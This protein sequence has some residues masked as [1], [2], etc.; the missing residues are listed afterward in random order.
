MKKALLV[1]LVTA[2]YFQANAQCTLGAAPNGGDGTP[3]LP[4]APSC[5]NQNQTTNGVGAGSFQTIPG[6]T[7]STNYELYYNTQGAPI[8]CVTARFTTS[9]GTPATAWTN[10]N[11]ANSAPG[12]FTALQSCTG[13]DRLEVRT[14]RSSNWINTSAL[15]YYRLAK[16]TITS[17]GTVAPVC[18]SA[19]S[20]TTTLPYTATTNSPTSYSI[21]WASGLTDVGT[22]SLAFSSGSGTVTISVPAGLAAG[23]YTGVM[24]ITNSNACTATLNITLTIQALPSI[25]TNPTNKSACAAGG[26][27]FTV[28]GA[29]TGVAYAWQVSTD[30]GTTFANITAAGTNPTYAN[31]TTSTLGLSGIV[32]GNSGYQYRAV[33]SGTCTPSVTSTAATLTVVTQPSVTTAANGTICTGSSFNMAV[34][35]SNG[36]SITHQ[37]QYATALAGTYTSVAPGVPAGA[38]YSGNTTNSLT[39]SGITAAGTYYYRDAITDAG[40]G[41]ND[42]FSGPTTLTV[43]AQP[44][45]SAPANQA[46]CLGGSSSFTSNISNG[47][48]P[49]GQWQYAST[50]TGTYASV[51]DG[52]PAGA[53]YT[54]NTTATLSVSGISATGTYYYRLAV[55][56]GGTG[57]SDPFSA[58]ASLTIS[59]QPTVT[60]APDVSV[61][62]GGAVNLPVTVTNGG[63]PTHQWQYATSLAGTYASVA[64]GTPTG[65]TYSGAT[66]ATLTV[67]GITA[68]GTYYYRD[69][70]LDAG[71]NCADP[72]S[73]PTTVT[74]VT[75]PT[76]TAASPATFT[77]CVGGSLSL[78][79]TSS[80]G[81][82]P[83]YQWQY[84][85]ALAG[86]YTSV[87][88]G[89]P[90][91]ATYSGNTTNNLTVSGITA[92]GTYY[93]RNAV[94]DAGAG[95]NDP[96]SAPATY[97]VRAQTTVS[98]AANGTICTGGSF[99]MPVTVTNGVSVTHQWQYATAIGGPY[100]SVVNGTPTGATYTGNTTTSLTV[101]GI[102]AA[103]TYYYRDAVTDAGNNCNDPFSGPT[104][105]AVRAQPTVT[106]PT[107]T[108]M[109][110]TSGTASFSAPTSN[111]TT[112]TYQWQYATAIAGTYS[113]VA[114][115]T[116]AGAVYSGNTTT[117]LTVS[118][119]TAA[120]TYYYRLAVTDAGSG[121]TDPF[122]APASLTVRAQ[123]TVAAP[124]AQTICV[125]G[126]GTMSAAAS[127]GVSPTYQW[128]YA[129]ALAGTYTSVADGT[130]A[131][132]VYTGATASSLTVSGITAAGTYYYRNAVTDAGSGCNDP[133]SAPAAF[134][135]R[136]QTTV[137]TAANG[138][139]CTGGSFAMPVTVTNGV[140]VTHQWQYATAIGGPYASVAAGTP[141]GA[142]YTGNTT[143]SLTVSG[144]TAAGTYYY[145]DAVTDAG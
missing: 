38:T 56:D 11:Y 95:C 76:I 134:T 97:T 25:T 94:T 45:A 79:A 108:S 27:T 87:A 55:T 131:G 15:L 65:A 29:G 80:N 121:C 58:P 74:V 118:G 114:P 98:T 116:P 1:L 42:P 13:C 70:I 139:I 40:D 63:T 12:T 137:S 57:C 24:T 84:A 140:S 37:W 14:G 129:T 113:S 125:G 122:S 89:T 23:T 7:G 28:A 49:T 46:I 51:V 19:S 102:T 32:A 75:Q 64:A 120:G 36:I 47:I 106:A 78:T 8:N 92:A 69:A 104:T 77:G 132:A 133:F 34:S 54:G 96:F 115:G 105:L 135:V 138:T 53:V 128:Q 20:Q 124:T 123:P 60:P 86:T 22:T 145:R 67:S 16:P 18:Y 110:V 103:G 30:G 73:S 88:D 107:N 117:G 43:R 31:W 35:A 71:N 44:T 144:I 10:I 99:A 68:L 48:S 126:S 61:C 66:T 39:V 90:A 112:P 52:T 111:G 130:P 85:T 141:A 142:T 127:N 59:T 3:S 91:G 41:C 26:T 9:S 83:T 2:F 17:T 100:A 143:T 81:I 101:S 50:L 33:V 6:F 4:T 119:I 21:N 82:T 62:A 72:F 93:Y 109:C 5:S 136:P